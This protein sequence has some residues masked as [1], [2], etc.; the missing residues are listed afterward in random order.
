MVDMILA[1]AFRAL[2]VWFWLYGP[3]AQLVATLCHS[4]CGLYLSDL[5][6]TFLDRFALLFGH[7]KG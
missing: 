1:A 5:I 7:K 6:A 3:L 2:G 4:P